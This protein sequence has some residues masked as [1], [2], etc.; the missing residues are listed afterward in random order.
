MKKAPMIEEICLMGVSEAP[1]AA[2]AVLAE[3]RVPKSL[4]RLNLRWSGEYESE[5]ACLV[6]RLRGLGL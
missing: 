3:T 5:E 2:I 6:E 1:L 4:E